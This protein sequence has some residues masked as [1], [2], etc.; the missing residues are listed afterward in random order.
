MKEKTQTKGQAVSGLFIMLLF[1]VFVLCALFLSL[2]EA[3]CMKISQNAVMRI[4]Q[5]PLH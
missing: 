4:F 2:W 1:L 3:R 5:A